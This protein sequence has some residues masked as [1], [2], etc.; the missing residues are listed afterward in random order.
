MCD[1]CSWIE[2]ILA[3]INVETRLLKETIPPPYVDPTVIV[4]GGAGK[5]PKKKQKLML[6]AVKNA[7][8]KAYKNLIDGYTAVDAIEIAISCMED[9]L[10]L[11]Y[12]KEAPM[13]TNDEIV[14][15]A[16][17]MTNDLD[18]GSIGFIQGIE[19]PIK[20][21]REV[22]K[23]TDHVLI[24]ENGAT[25]LAKEADLP[26]LMRKFM[27]TDT[28]R[29][30]DESEEE[31]YDISSSSDSTDD[32]LIKCANDIKND[33]MKHKENDTSIIKMYFPECNFLEMEEIEME[34][35]EL[36]E[37]NITIPFHEARTVGAVAYDRKKRLSSGISTMKETI[38]T[39]GSISAVGTV[40]G[41]GIYADENGCCSLSGN[42]KT[43][44]KYAP[45]RKI[46][47]RFNSKTTMMLEINN[48]LDKF[49]K[50]TGES[51]IGVIALN[52]KGE[53]SI[54]FKTLHFPWACCRNGYIYYGCNKCDKFLEEIRD[55]NRP[56]D[57][58]CEVSR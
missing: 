16:G 26:I 10:Y 44:Y 43:I 18:A 49:Q 2:Q 46:V 38:K 47:R 35:E 53:P 19:H 1:Y 15:D 41:C 5:I 45:A 9:T 36:T 4:H 31:Y 27:P 40:I 34:D 51:E 22:L 39:M 23:N 32:F 55:L 56:L 13:H 7:A 42:D 29:F 50:E 6:E 14:W 17:I 21:A 58:M 20:L 25:K 24:V 30:I 12:T 3:R 52:N 54:S 11:N 33:Y 48:E 8:L 28:I 57:C 37:L